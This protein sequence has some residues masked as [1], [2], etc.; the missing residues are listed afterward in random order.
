MAPLRL[1]VKIDMMKNTLSEYAI[2][3]S[4]ELLNIEGAKNTGACFAGYLIAG[5]ASLSPFGL[6]LGAGMGAAF[7]GIGTA[8]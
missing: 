4:S 3:D 8:S 7:C 6:A 5:G 2:L 1:G